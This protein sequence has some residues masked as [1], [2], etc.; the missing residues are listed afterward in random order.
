MNFR[1]VISAFDVVSKKCAPKDEVQAD[2][3]KLNFAIAAR[4]IAEIMKDNDI[5]RIDLRLWPVITC[6]D[7]IDLIEQEIDDLQPTLLTY[8]GQED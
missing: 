7:N 4:N 8:L 2:M 6:T 1:T 3:N 5:I